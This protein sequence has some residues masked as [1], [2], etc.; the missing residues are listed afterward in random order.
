[1]TNQVSEINLTPEDTAAAEA[2][3]LAYIEQAKVK[4]NKIKSTLSKLSSALLS[5]TIPGED[6]VV[7]NTPNVQLTTQRDMPK[8]MDNK[9]LTLP[10]SADSSS[11]GTEQSGFVI[12]DSFST[13]IHP[14]TGQ[15]LM[16]SDIPMDVKAIS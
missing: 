8:D 12:P 16:D 4:T 9:E 10:Q 15:R 7:V 6:P 3:Q 13:S 2:A 1:M 5:S 14:I 11:T